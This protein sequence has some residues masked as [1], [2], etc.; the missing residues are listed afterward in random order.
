M[1]DYD[2]MLAG[3]GLVGAATAVGLARSGLRVAVIEASERKANHQPSY[4]DRTL[5]I[6]AAS[7][8]ILSGLDLLPAALERMPVREIRITRAGGFGHLQLRAADYQRDLFGAVIVAR[9]LGNVMLE[10]LDQYP[11]ITQ[12][13]PARLETFTVEENQVR[14]RLGDGSLLSTRLLIGSD[15][16]DS[17]VRQIAAIAAERHDYGQSAMIFNVQAGRAPRDTAWERFTPRGPLALLPQPQG[18]LGTVWIDRSEHIDEAMDWDDET[19]I[20]RLTTR[21]GNSLGGFS[22]PGKR[23]RYPL[24]RV[25]TR[26]PVADRVAVVGNAANSVHPVSAQGFNLGLRDVAVLVET[27]ARHDDPGSSE[28]L[29]AYAAARFQDQ[30]ATVRYTDTLARAFTNPSLL[31]RMGTGLG[32]AAHAAIPGLSRRLVQAAMGFRDPV[33]RLARGHS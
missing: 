15:G 23:A 7:L 27:L 30:E 6:N 2:V 13:C 20:Q 25:R 28:T 16:S 32:L 8:N 11:A 10:A 31:A 12:L 3:G 33:T 14:V 17:M 29:A 5:V 18:R 24:V 4:D 19:L 22:Q 21:F 1:T 26:H 9:E